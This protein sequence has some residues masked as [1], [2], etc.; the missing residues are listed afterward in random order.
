MTVTQVNK[1][2]VPKRYQCEVPIKKPPAVTPEADKKEGK[3]PPKK[4]A[5]VD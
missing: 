5:T 3:T 1:K 2:V 4:E